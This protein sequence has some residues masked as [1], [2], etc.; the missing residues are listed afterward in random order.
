MKL[1]F[2]SPALHGALDYL[3]ASALIVLPFLLSFTGIELWLSVAGG[4]G[5]IL[6]SLITDYQFGLAKLLP[7]NL[8]LVLDLS[9]GAALFV[10]P[11]LL[12]FGAIASIYYPVMALGVFAVVTVSN[13]IPAK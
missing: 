11:F 6:Y 10:A 13:R 12:D 3:A 7:F 2:L 1:Q 5:L 4:A 8:H 9:A